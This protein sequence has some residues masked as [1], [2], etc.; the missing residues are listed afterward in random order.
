MAARAITGDGAGVWAT[1]TQAPGAVKV[2]LLGVLVNRLT[3]FLTIFLAL[4]LY[5]RG[6]S[7]A[8]TAVVVG[9]YGAGTVLSYL[10]GGPLAAALGTRTV[11]VV[12][13]A[14]S[15][16]LLAVLLALSDFALVAT[17]VTLA[18]VAS[19]LY[20]PAS[21]TMLSD[22]TPQHRQV[23]IQAMYRFAVNVGSAAAPLLGFALYRLDRDYT[24]V[25]LAQALFGLGYAVLARAV[26]PRRDPV[27]DPP[28]VTHRRRRGGHYAAVLADRRFVLFLIAGFFSTA[29]Y[30]QYLATLPLDIAASGLPVFW[31]SA[32]VS[33]NGILVILF[34]LPLTKLSQR[35]PVRPVVIATFALVGLGM[36]TYGLPL[37]PVVVV[38]G[39]LLW[40]LGE[41]IGGPRVFAYPAVAAPMALKPYYISAFQFTFGLAGAVGQTVGV[42]LFAALGHRVWPFLALGSALAVLFAFVA[43]RPRGAE[44]H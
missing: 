33:L 29:V 44:P 19:Q 27:R 37:V 7:A 5:A 4:L 40:T 22:L 42:S 38:T 32:A 13:L 36:A 34:E 9:L 41:M 39:T 15:A 11:T 20:W 8:Q 10:V 25:L 12:S 28:P 31:Y 24:Y 23:M 3:G 43:L 14:C 30:T 1:I 18:G 6:Y 26:L 16:V 2:I 21:V 17:T 35:L